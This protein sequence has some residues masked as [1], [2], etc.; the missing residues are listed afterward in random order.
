MAAADAT[1]ASNFRPAHPGGADH[2]QFAGSLDCIPSID[3]AV[4]F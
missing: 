1:A 3:R 2:V 4:V